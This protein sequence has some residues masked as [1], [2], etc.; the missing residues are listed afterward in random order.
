MKQKLLLLL[1]TVLLAGTTMVK[2]DDITVGGARRT[3]Y[4]YIPKDLGEKRPL[5]I[6]MHGMNQDANYQK[7]M[8][9]I[10]S[11]ADTA[12][13]AV[14]FPEGEGRSWDIGGTKD[15]N[16]VLAIISDMEKKYGIDTDRVY[17]SGFSMGGMFTYHAIN[18]IAD[19]IAAFAPISGYP[20]GGQAF[21]SSRPVPIFHTHGTS[22][23]VVNFGG[24]QPILDGWI[25]RNNCCPSADVVS[26]YRANHATKHTWG[27]GDDNCEVVLLELADKGHW[28]ANDFFKT[29]E[30]IW[31][32]CKRYSLH[33]Q[34]PEVKFKTPVNGMEILG[35]GNPKY[36]LTIEAVATS[37]NSE[38][39]SVSFYVDNTLLGT[40]TEAPYVWSCDNLGIGNHS[41]KVSATDK[42]GATASRMLRPITTKRI[43]SKYDVTSR[44]KEE[45][46]VPEGW[47]LSNGRTVRKG[48]LSGVTGGTHVIKL[49]GAKRSFDYGIYVPNSKGGANEAYAIFGDPATM[50]TMMFSSGI[51]EVTFK[52]CKWDDATN[53]TVTAQLVNVDT[54][55]V[56]AQ[57]TVTPSVNLAGDA[58]A[59]FTADNVTLSFDLGYDCPCK[60]V[61]YADAAKKSDML[62]GG[63]TI[64]RK[65][66]SAIETV[67]SDASVVS[68]TYYDLNGRQCTDQSSGIVIRRIQYSDGTVKSQK[69]VKT[70][71]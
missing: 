50:V 10:E 8:L 12:K 5:L 66:A 58:A 43:R 41:V 3:Y 54:G 19:R 33:Q 39:E 20:M 36:P 16:F 38:I 67:E 47:I 31:N 45:N 2:A 70:I 21:T 13:F 34:L 71:R 65:G 35:L 48:P 30:E 32:F 17:L 27:P 40:V 60:L 4:K 63:I 26:P 6:S 52:V 62:L 14:V 44:I 25:K 42:N 23:D 11:V 37:T 53:S 24:A 28:I 1:L 46:I 18:H 49:T 61:F 56:L 29:G 59:S 9:S 57:T 68:V 55:E 7:G 64:T 15:I 69:V 22:D 51:Y